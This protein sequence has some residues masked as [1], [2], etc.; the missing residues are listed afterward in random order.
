MG[1]LSGSPITLT[2][3]LIDALGVEQPMEANDLLTKA[4]STLETDVKLALQFF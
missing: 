2:A 1:E 3:N 4:E